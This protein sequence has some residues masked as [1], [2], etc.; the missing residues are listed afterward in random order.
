MVTAYQRLR[1]QRH[2]GHAI[3]KG[4]KL[5]IMY[6]VA[7]FVSRLKYLPFMIFPEDS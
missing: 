1:G 4:N 7:G 5:S 2:F 3:Q 6:F